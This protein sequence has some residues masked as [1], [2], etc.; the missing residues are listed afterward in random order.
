M[1]PSILVGA[2]SEVISN[3]AGLASD[4]L[5]DIFSQTE[6]RKAACY[7]SAT[8]KAEY[9]G[10]RYATKTLLTK[11][12]LL[13]TTPLHLITIDSDPKGAPFFRLEANSPTEHV[14]TP[15]LTSYIISLT[16]KTGTIVAM[17]APQAN[18]HGIGIDLE[19]RTAQRP[20]E[21]V[22]HRMVD[23]IGSLKE[24][25]L[26]EN[27]LVN[28]RQ[29]PGLRVP[30]AADTDP[31]LTLFSIKEASYKAL[32]GEATTL[33]KIALDSFTP[34]TIPGISLPCFRSTLSYGNQEL[35][36]ITVELS[37]FLFSVAW[38]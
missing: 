4:N 29:K 15:L 9:L 1:V 16:H 12:L 22:N 5:P 7:A 32:R 14:I 30:P 21:R 35:E 33:K 20:I 36:A 18:Y 37:F 31:F 25:S 38:Y 6:I 3:P 2:V 27:E 13:P 23:M 26:I 11:I 17:L 8:R 28:V 10:G 34:H 19:Y 24:S